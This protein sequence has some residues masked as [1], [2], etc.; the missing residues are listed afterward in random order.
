MRRAGPLL[1]GWNSHSRVRDRNRIHKEVLFVPL[2]A[3]VSH[4]GCQHVGCFFNLSGHVVQIIFRSGVSFDDFAKML[5][6]FF[7][8]FDFLSPASRMPLFEP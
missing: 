1:Q 8:F 7:K 4:K 6:A 5:G 2:F 3:N